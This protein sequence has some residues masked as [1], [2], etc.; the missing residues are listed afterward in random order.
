MQKQTTRKNYSLR[1]A[2]WSTLEVQSLGAG[3]PQVH[4]QPAHEIPFH[5]DLSYK[6]LEA[7]QKELKKYLQSES[8]DGRV[9]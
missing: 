3:K 8:S 1:D 5:R 9:G 4:L 6:D 7:L 2:N